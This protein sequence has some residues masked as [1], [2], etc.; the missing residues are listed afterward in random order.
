M[1]TTSLRDRDYLQ[2]AFRIADANV[3]K[4]I[5]NRRSYSSAMHKFTD[6]TLGGNLW[7]NPPPQFSPVADPRVSRFFNDQYGGMGRFYSDVIDDNANVIYLQFG[8]PEFNGILTFFMNMFDPKQSVLARKGRMDDWFFAAGEALGAITFWP[9][10]L[11]SIGVNTIRY[12]MGMPKTQYYYM[13]ST[14]PL[15]WKTAESML[16]QLLINSGWVK[17]LFRTKHGGEKVTEGLQ[18]GQ[19]L[20]TWDYGGDNVNSFKK[21]ASL[22]PN[23]YREDGTV[24]LLYVANRGA[25][26]Y[27]SWLSA[28]KTRLD[29]TSAQ[30]Y[31][32]MSKLFTNHQQ[33]WTYNSNNESQK[34][35]KSDGY[36]SSY[37]QA[38]LGK[39]DENEL[40]TPEPAGQYTIDESGN[41]G[42]GFTYSEE[43]KETSFTTKLYQHLLD[44]LHNGGNYVGFKVDNVGSIGE[45]FSNSAA[46]SQ[47]SQQLNGVTS[48]VS[49]AAF[50]FSGGNTGIGVIDAFKD[51]VMSVVNGFISGSVIGGL[52]MMLAGQSYVDI[53]KH[54]NGS[55][56]DLPSESYTFQLRATYAHPISIINKI[57]VPLCLLLA[58]AMPRATG[59]A[60]YTSPFLCSLFSQG[61]WISNLSMISSIRVERGTGNVG[62]S[63]DK[64]PLAVDVTIQVMDLSSIITVPTTN[65][66][67]PSD[68][69][70]PARVVSQQIFG[71]DTKYNDYMNTIA[72]TSFNDNLLKSIN[73]GKRLSKLSLDIEKWVDP[74]QMASSFAGSISGDVLRAFSDY[75]PR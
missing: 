48:Q 53:P 24:D 26:K 38:G 21:V 61:R 60:S 65:I 4:V 45:T 18:A 12:F 10:Q 1:A 72:A 57:Y 71:D 74:R 31:D 43:K 30:G 36:L 33:N 49:E 14:M 17:T 63:K 58:G 47:L 42:S 9:L 11:A 55:N 25:R 32:Q 8:V 54:W 35:N 40:N 51:S 66:I 73:L 52:P 68:I 16:N 64:K 46:E 59:A 15:Y 27:R 2:Q 6:T 67:K 3:D 44:E 20:S 29:S 28:L 22:Y 13:K 39:L 56:C 19:N 69:A 75:I 50:T 62:W 23:I 70:G 41:M 34:A 5:L 7:I 37:L